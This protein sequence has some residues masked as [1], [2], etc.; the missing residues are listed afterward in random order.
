MSMKKLSLACIR[1][2]G[3]NK[4]RTADADFIESIRANGMM[5]PI[6][7][8]FIKTANCF[9]IV[10]GE[11]R[12]DAAKKLG[13]KD[14]DATVVDADDL[15]ARELCLVENINRANLAPMDEA[16]EVDALLKLHKGDVREVAARLGRSRSFVR[17]RANLASLDPR[18]F[19][20]MDVGVDS[21]PVACL[22]LL[23][24]VPEDIQ[25]KIAEENPWAIPNVY[26]LQ[27]AVQGLTRSVKGAPWGRDAV[28]PC[29]DCAKR[30]G[31]DAD[32]FGEQDGIIGEGDRCLDAECYAQKERDYI[33]Q[34]KASILKRFQKC[35]LVA[36]DIPAEMHEE[37]KLQKV[38][39]LDTPFRADFTTCK[40]TDAGSEPAVIWCGEGAGI[41]L[42]VKRVVKKEDPAQSLEARRLAW[43]ADEVRNQLRALLE[44]I[45]DGDRESLVAAMN[46]LTNGK[47]EEAVAMYEKEAEEEVK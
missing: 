16:A 34:V 44:S 31:A 10:A 21:I 26:R 2:N 45:E 42:W 13:R 28:P 39:N 27:A 3:W 41:A 5:N 38:A 8:R 36:R 47:G 37:A 9:E 43:V 35:N 15:R 23:A 11:R 17:Q 24:K 12:F 6:T 18:L 7:V 4:K 40:K 32:L 30:T 46:S 1:P 14:I 25:R 22:E 29:A 20:G 33:G 19:D